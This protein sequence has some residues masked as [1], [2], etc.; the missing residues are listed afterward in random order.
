MNLTECALLVACVLASAAAAPPDERDCICQRVPSG[1]RVFARDRQDGHAAHVHHMLLAAHEAAGGCHASYDLVYKPLGGW[2]DQIR[3]MVT[4]FYAAALTHRG[5]A[6][7]WSPLFRVGDYFETHLATYSRADEAAKLE[8]PVIDAAGNWTYFRDPTAIDA[9]LSLNGSAVVRTNAWQWTELTRLPR[10]RAAAELLGVAG[11]SQQALY[12][13]AVQVML[14]RPAPAVEAHVN[15]L[16][17]RPADVRIEFG[18]RPP[19]GKHGMRLL[20][21]G[22]QIR[23]GGIGEGWEEDNL[24]RTSLPGV[25]CFAAEAARLCG[26]QCLVF[27][28]ADSGAAAAR[29]KAVLAAAAG[30]AAAVVEHVGLVL[31]TDFPVPAVALGKPSSDP[32][33]KTFVDWTALSQV[34]A[35]LMSRSGFGWTAG[36]AGRAPYMRMMRDGAECAW[37]D[38]ETPDGLF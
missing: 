26:A 10:L 1:V 4:A 13:L 18:R 17:G 14:P 32:W 20:T 37:F 7:M 5:F 16:L 30:A 25:D 29:F 38:F 2:G 19:R 24:V 34:D 23:T 31:H 9:L 36:W 27:L 33:Q 21:I 6:T 28:T 12:V 15:T 8:A 22:V 3:G 35:L 11:M